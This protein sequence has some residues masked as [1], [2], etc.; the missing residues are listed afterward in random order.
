ML[1]F[2]HVDLLLDVG[3]N[4][5]Q[6]AASMREAGYRG[7]IVSFEPLS[8]PR[9]QLLDASRPD[10]G[11]EIAPAVAIGAEEGN[12]EMRISDNSFS[13]SVLPVLPEHIRAAPESVCVGVENVPLSRL[14]TASRDYLSISKSPFLK[15]DTQGFESQVLD[16]A[17]EVLERAVGLHLELSFVPLYEGQTLFDAVINR[18]EGLGFC[19]WGFWP[20]IHDPDSGRMLQIDATLFRRE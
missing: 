17:A 19:V 18:L 13:S 10:P 14:D 11:W 8:D 16:G 2:H 6:F 4:V 9:A 3:A 7:K 1:E 12:V 5:G 20:G 15:I